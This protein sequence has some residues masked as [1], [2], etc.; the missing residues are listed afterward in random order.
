MVAVSLKKKRT[1]QQENNKKSCLS[2]S[3]TL[4]TR[5]CFFLVGSFMSSK[6][7]TSSAMMMSSDFGLSA[8]C[9]YGGLEKNKIDELPWKSFYY[10][11]VILVINLARYLLVES[12]DAQYVVRFHYHIF[13]IEKPF[14]LFC[15][16]Y[17]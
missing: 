11:P 17:V 14:L 6:F 15:T 7:T 16:Y 8:G 10:E 13:V 4:N 5:D 2:V 1:Q 12:A 9:F 3:D